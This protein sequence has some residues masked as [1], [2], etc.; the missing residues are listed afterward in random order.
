MRSFLRSVSLWLLGIIAT[1]CS[2]S[3]HHQQAVLPEVIA[4]D[5]TTLKYNLQLDFMKHHFSGM[6]VAR[7][8]DDNEIRLLFSTYFG[9]SVFDFSLRGD[10]LHINSCVPPMRKEKLLR[11][12]EADFGQLF[13]SGQ[14]VR[15]KQK[16]SI[17]ERRIG[18]KGIAKAVISLSDFAEGQPRQIRIKHPWI[19]LK[20]Q[21]DKLKDQ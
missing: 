11:I 20:I 10:S 17:F 6:L 19:R 16:S 21:L 5:S 9:L 1:C 3:I 2:P 14:K 13:L 18:G 4:T 8:M 12:L 15:I 7:R